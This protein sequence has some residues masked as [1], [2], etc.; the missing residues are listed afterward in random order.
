MSPFKIQSPTSSEVPIL[1][2]VP[3]CGTAFPDELKSQYKPNL[4]SAPDDTD[5]FVDQLYDF[6]PAMGMTMVS[7][8]HSRW[9]ID[10]NRDPESK[11]LYTDGRIITAL[12][13]AT[14]FLGEPIYNDERKGVET[15]EVQRRLKQYYW[16]YHEKLE[17]ELAR[18]KSKFG[19]VL[20]W[21][22]HSIRQL[23][24]TIQKEKFPDLILGSADEKSAS[25]E[26][27]K[28]ALK[29]LS[30]GPYR[31]NHNHPFKGGFITRNFGKPAENQHALQ[32]EMCKVHYMDDQEMK[33]DKVRA[34]KMREILKRTL[35]SLAENLTM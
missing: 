24:P 11:P 19:K 5:W 18:L 21:D 31:L 13:P 14:T 7:A 15:S 33:Y 32:L 9:V 6:A 12:C 3:H 25:A 17:Q 30:S 22:C 26:I 8:V 27:I 28:S 16:P 1:V 35:G 23:V 29:D 4:T 20:L 10:L 34:D 2:S